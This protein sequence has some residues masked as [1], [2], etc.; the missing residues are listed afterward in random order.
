VRPLTPPN[1]RHIVAGLLERGPEHL[2]DF[3]ARA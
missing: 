3:S 2:T 1:S